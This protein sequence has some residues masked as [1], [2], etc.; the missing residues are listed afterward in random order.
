MYTSIL[1]PKPKE[2]EPVRLEKLREALGIPSLREFWRQ[3]TDRGGYECSYEAVRNWHDDRPAPGRYYAAVAKAFSV[4]LR[5]LLL[6]EG[7]MWVRDA[8]DQWGLAEARKI[9]SRAE[10]GFHKV[11]TPLTL[12]AFYAAWRAVERSLPDNQA[13][14]LTPDERAELGR[15]VL[16]V[17][18][19][20]RLA[21]FHQNRFPVRDMELY[22]QAA[23]EAVKLATPEPGAGLPYSMVLEKLKRAVPRPH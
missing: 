2:P 17:A 6:G 22:W 3:V 5:W 7:E 4:D 19:Q 15:A 20:P 9:V 1:N 23:F 8:P 13:E 11:A 21:L 10:S 12:S 16:R 18:Y 14:K